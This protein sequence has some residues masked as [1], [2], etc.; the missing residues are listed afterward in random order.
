MRTIGQ[1]I[2]AIMDVILLPLMPIFV[3]MMEIIVPLIPEIQ[4][5]ASAFL[6]PIVNFIVPKLQAVKEWVEKID[7]SALETWVAKAGETVAGWMGTVYNWFINTLYPWFSNT[8]W[9]WLGAAYSW[10]KNTAYPWIKEKI[11]DVAAWF[12]TNWPTIWATLSGWWSS[13]SSWFS[14]NWPTIWNTISGWWISISSWF[15]HVDW[16]GIL[17]SIKEKAV[18]VYNWLTGTCWPWLQTLI[19]ELREWFGDPVGKA[20]SEGA[21]AAGL[22][23]EE[24]ADAYMYSREVQRG[25][26]ESM[27]S[28]TVAMNEV[29]RHMGDFNSAEVAA[30][31]AREL[32]LAFQ[33]SNIPEEFANK[34]LMDFSKQMMTKMIFGDDSLF[35]IAMKTLMAE[36]IIPQMAGGGYVPNNTLAFLHAG[37]TVVPAGQNASSIEMQNI[38]NIQLATT[39]SVDDLARDIEKKITD[40]LSTILRRQ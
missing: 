14:T 26:A 27:K 11:G 25:I 40:R 9:P 16:G 39:G 8:L 7:W 10:I 17:D 36:G 34:T 3:K 29:V 4:K 21:Q 2:G 30:I 32:G 23:T 38:F 12:V 37:E 18:S 24:E 33:A 5:L 1:I 22:A 19:A 28:T 13:I 20:F 35:E 6:T 31:S 15:S